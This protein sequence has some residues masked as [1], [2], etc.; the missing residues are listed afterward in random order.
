MLRLQSRRVLAL[1]VFSA[2]AGCGGG[3]SD[4]GITP[5]KTTALQVVS[6]AG[7]TDT[8]L[9]KLAQPLT[10]EVRAAG[11][12][13]GGAT[14][15]FLALPPTDTVRQGDAAVL[16]ASTQAGAYGQEV[17]TTTASDGT[18]RVQV[19]L[20]IVAGTASVAISCPEL[21]L[22]DT[23]RFTVTP[24]ATVRIVIVNWDQI[25]QVGTSYSVNAYAVDAHGNRKPD[26]LTYAPGR[27]VASVDVSGRA[28]VGA[29][30]GRGVVAVRAGAVVDSAVVAVVPSASIAFLRYPQGAIGTMRLDGTQ[31][32]ILASTTTTAYPS[33]SWTSDLVVYHQ[34][35]PSGAAVYVVDSSGVKRR[36]LDQSVMRN[37]M[38]PN[39][40]HDGQ[41]VYF[42]GNATDTSALAIWRVHPDG[43]GL[44]RIIAISANADNIRV[45]DSPDGSKIAYYDGVNVIVL[46][47][48]SGIQ[49]VISGGSFPTFSPDGQRIAFLANGGITIVNADGSGKVVVAEGSVDQNAG[50][51]WLPDGKW[52]LARSFGGVRMQSATTSEWAGLNWYDVYQVSA[53]P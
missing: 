23:A 33:A 28:T 43:S 7:V 32:K 45:S 4:G 44:Q 3:Q 29:V 2:V 14:V 47:L 24:G 41:F 9:A 49:T 15:R 5:P 19:Q 25:A 42:A 48:A 18:A 52:L 20:G 53:R 39:F 8:M 35:D 36:L 26:A 21:G 22:S 17:V 6:G 12:P 50:V 38:F 34:F 11:Q 30:P 51:T 37:A 27:L 40:S 31:R 13:R 10:I 16:V 1:L 46:Q